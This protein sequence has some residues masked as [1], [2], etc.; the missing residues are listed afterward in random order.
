MRR[1]SLVFV[2]VLAALAVTVPAAPADHGPRLRATLDDCHRGAMPA[3]RVAQFTGAM[4]ARAG[5]ERMWMRF[6]L[7][8]RRAGSDRWVRVRRAATFGRWEKSEPRRRGFVF[9]KRVDALPVP[10]HYRAVVR[11][12]WYDAD[13][14]RQAS[15]TRRTRS[16]WQPDVRADLEPGAV[17]AALDVAS[18]MARYAVTVRNAGRGD[19]GSS[20][21]ALTAGDGPPRLA[22]VPGLPRGGSAT[23]EVLAPACL[24]GSVVHVLADADERVDERDEDDNDARAPCPL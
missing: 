6:D 5:T 17:T 1:S 16:C 20:A 22:E 15:S 24:P 7:Y 3:D 13:G 18:G 12:R 8:R 10:Y 11:F 9:H 2:V 23:V 14:E 4:P 19:A 21:V